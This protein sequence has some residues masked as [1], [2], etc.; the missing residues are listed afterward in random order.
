MLQFLGLTFYRFDRRSS[1]EISFTYGG[2]NLVGGTV[3][4]PQDAIRYL[5][6]NEKQQYVF[7]GSRFTVFMKPKCPT[8]QEGSV[9]QIRNKWLDISCIASEHIAH[10][11]SGRV[12][13]FVQI[14]TVIF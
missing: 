4:C 3:K 12:Y 2:R 5:G 10:L 7:Y 13:T 1:R 11:L 14:V 6:T 9:T 8:I